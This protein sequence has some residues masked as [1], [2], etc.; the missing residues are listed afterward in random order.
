VNSLIEAYQGILAGT[1]I[2][3]LGFAVARAG[4]ALPEPAGLDVVREAGPR[5][6]PRS[7]GPAARGSQQGEAVRSKDSPRGDL[8]T[9][10]RSMSDHAP[11]YAVL[12]LA[13]GLGIVATP[14]VLLA[15]LLF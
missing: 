5:D 15:L 3:S 8:T 4:L 11:L 13:L 2:A 10:N 14:L 7:P 9:H 1:R 6:P 12:I